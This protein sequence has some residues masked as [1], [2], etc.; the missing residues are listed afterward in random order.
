VVR[1]TSGP[2]GGSGS[3]DTLSISMRAQATTDKGGSGS[4][5]DAFSILMGQATSDPDGGSAGAGAASFSIL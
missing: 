2:D 3:T 5:D 1:A 4:T